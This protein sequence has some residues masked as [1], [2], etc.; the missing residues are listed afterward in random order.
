MRRDDLARLVRV[1]RQSHS[2]VQLC[3]GTAPIGRAFF[4]ISQPRPL[5]A[6]RTRPFAIAG[7]A[8]ARPQSAGESI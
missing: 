8:F 6:R 7:Q 1:S 4:D 3:F 5:P 2:L